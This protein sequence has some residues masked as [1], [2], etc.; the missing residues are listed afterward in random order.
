MNQKETDVLVVGAGPTGL[1]LAAALA[2][3]GIRVFIID[4]Q[5]ERSPQSKAL[6]IQAGTLEALQ[7]DFGHTL[8]D[9]LTTKGWKAQRGFL[10]FGKRSNVAL[11]LS[12][13]PSRHNYILVLSQED[14]EKLLEQNLDKL[15]THITRQT[16]LVSYEDQGTHISAKVRND[17][18]VETT[19]RAAFL[20]GC[21]GAHSTVRHLA[22]IPFVGRAMSGAF[23]LGDV[24]VDWE[25]GDGSLR[26][27]FSKNGTLVCIP[28][29]GN[30]RYRLITLQ[31]LLK[32][33]TPLLLSE[34]E[35]LANG[36]CPFQMRLSAPTWLTRFHVNQRRTERFRIG[37][38]LLAGDAAHIHSPA[39]GQGMNTGIQDALCLASLL[40]RT[41]K[42]GAPLS[43]LDEY[44]SERLPVAQAVLRTTGW[45]TRFALWGARF[46]LSWVRAWLAPSLLRSSLIQRALTRQLSQVRIAR[47]GIETRRLAAWVHN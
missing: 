41:L 22:E 44:E 7:D 42:Q 21:D 26:V 1:T 30:H 3:R 4:K 15:A 34:L 11:D 12:L 29:L 43:V 37:R 32:A 27:F 36:I 31:N 5:S 35:S 16:T 33:E 2:R 40:N 17:A 14:T 24:E 46:P 23:A 39:G 20:V 9:Q 19:V 45:L 25:L 28:L 10:H 18:G 38:V 8:V 13:I 6:A 47:K